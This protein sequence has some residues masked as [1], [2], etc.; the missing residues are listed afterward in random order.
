MITDRENTRDHITLRTD[1][2]TTRAPNSVARFFGLDSTSELSD[3][4]GERS[5]YRATRRV[6]VVFPLGLLFVGCNATHRS[7]FDPGPTQTF[8]RPVAVHQ[9][10]VLNRGVSTDEAGFVAARPSE[11]PG[12]AIGESRYDITLDEFR[13]HVRNN[14]AV[15]VDARE[16]E[17]FAES[18]VRGALN[19]P[20]QQKEAYLGKISRN[21]GTGQFIIIYCG[22]PQCSAGD[23]V[24]DYAISQGYTNMRVFKPGWQILASARDLQ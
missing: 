23:S 1:T 8:V 3:Q 14:T 20:A 10:P 6:L 12:V 18:H 13:G 15:I 2:A 9:A 7:K 19:I 11:R 4:R 17:D 16:P 22:G 5:M 21:V 24:Y